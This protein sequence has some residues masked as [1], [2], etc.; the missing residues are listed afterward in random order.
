MTNDM[1]VNCICNTEQQLRQLCYIRKYVNVS[2]KTK[3][4]GAS[5]Q[6]DDDFESFHENEITWIV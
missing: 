4:N 5:F 6:I 3:I 2:L 1:K